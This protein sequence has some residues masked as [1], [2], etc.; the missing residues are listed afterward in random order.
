MAHP[1]TTDGA[2]APAV[3]PVEA[4]AAAPSTGTRRGS[5]LVLKLL[6]VA[7][8]FTLI[9]SRQSWSALEGALSKLSLLAL[10]LSIVL[11]VLALAIANL[12][13]RLL[14][15]AYG[16]QQLPNFWQLLRVFF[17]GQFYN[18]YLPGGVGGDVVRAIVLRRSFAR[19]G[20]TSGVAIVFVERALGVL[21]VLGV[22]SVTAAL[23]AAPGLREA[24][25]PY[26]VLGAVAAPGVVVAVAVGRRLARYA[27]GRVGALLSSLPVLER[28]TPFAL[29]CLLS[30]LT[31]VVVALAGH[32]L[33]QDIHPEAR[34]SDSLIAMPLSAAAAFLP[35][36]VAGAGP[37][38]VVLVA[39]YTTLGAPHAVGVATALAYLLTT[40]I[41]SGLGGLLQL[42]APLTKPEP[43]EHAPRASPAAPLD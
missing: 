19:G 20:T 26:C 8:G 9:L 15:R 34:L 36:S 30:A 25:L 23:G 22:F 10:T 6:V 42:I 28:V 32:A 31:Q 17:V 11:Q 27:P 35:L 38:D 29:A 43:G 39:L 16:A 12:R 7:L 2:A 37:R 18:T 1:S 41:V 4:D 40:W 3:V 14:L 33:I 21:G 13:W 5:W 24:F